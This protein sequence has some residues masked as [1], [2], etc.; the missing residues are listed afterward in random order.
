MGLFTKKIKSKIPAEQLPALLEVHREKSEFYLQAIRAFLFFLKEFSFDLMEIDAVGFKSLLDTLSKSFATEDSTQKI[1]RV[2]EGSK[3][4]ILSYIGREKVYFQ[5]R[6]TELRNII[7]L[8][9]KS[10]TELAGE[11]EVFN[12]QVYERNLRMEKLTFLDDIR[13]IKETL[14]SEV[15][16]MKRVVQEK[17]ARD[18][19]HL[20]MLSR[21][22]KLLRSDLEKAKDASQTDGLTGAYNRL[23]FDSY[24]R[25]LVERN[26]VSWDPF[27]IL[28]CD[29]DNFKKINDTYGHPVGDRVLIALIQKCKVM[30]RRDDFVARYGG[31]EFVV[32]LPRAPLRQAMKKARALCKAVAEGRYI[33]DN[34]RPDAKL[35]FSVS[36][37]AS[38]LR[39]NDTAETLINRADKALYQAKHSGKNRAI[40]EK[41]VA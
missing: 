19:Q 24:I 21:E 13:K 16:Q 20:E 7:E 6:E 2:F 37:G 14:K 25:K 34:A 9:G 40:S 38:F 29:I 30:F 28:M 4:S 17:Q 27:S 23:A 3:E 36:I 15:D 32:V 41:E 12:T 8:L 35:T 26:S 33:F 11:N 31:E 39:R 22:V 18:A 10:M 5:D 1:R